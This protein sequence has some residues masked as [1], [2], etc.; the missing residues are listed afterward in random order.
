MLDLLH[1]VGLQSREDL[2]KDAQCGMG[3]HRK[4]PTHLPP[5]RR[6]RLR[7]GARGRGSG[8]GFSRVSR[9]AGPYAVRLTSERTDAARTREKGEAASRRSQPPFCLCAQGGHGARSLSVPVVSGEGRPSSFS[10]HLRFFSLSFLFPGGRG[11]KQRGKRRGGRVGG[12]VGSCLRC[13]RGAGRIRRSFRRVEGEGGFSAQQLCRSLCG[14]AEGSDGRS[15]ALPARPCLAPAQV[16]A[17]TGPSSP[18]GPGDLPGKVAWKRARC[19]GLGGRVSPPGSAVPDFGH[20]E[21][22]S[23]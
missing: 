14:G 11:G 13:L 20:P 10:F 15:W 16:A 4:A 23:L 21:G 8:R 9:P 5:W 19:P 22:I 6:H 12:G 17:G 3:W 1:E 7:G 18:A 2:G